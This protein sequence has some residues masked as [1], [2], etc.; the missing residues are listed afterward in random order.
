MD[1]AL[2]AGSAWHA[3]TVD[4]VLK[5]LDTDPADGLSG[6]EAARRLVERGPNTLG[7]DRGPSRLGLLAHQFGD[8]LIWVLLAAALI[9]GLLLQE[10]IDAGVILAIV[11]VNAVLGYIQEARAEDALARLR[12]LSAPEAVVVRSGTERRIASADLVPGDLIVLEVGDRV[13]AD[14]RIIAEV[15]FEA[16]ESTLTGESFAV[17]KQEDPVAA[18]SMLGDQRSMVFA[19]TAASA[20]RARAIVTDTGRAT[21]V[22]QI[23]GVLSKK[24]PPTP[25]QIELDKVGRRLA[26]LAVATAAAVFATGMVRG[27]PAEA[28]FLTAVALAVA[29]IP[30]GLAAVVTIT[31]SG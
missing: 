2:P 8:V 30:E 5:A 1:G 4:E 15:H 27:K 21:Q 6:D 24:E 11:I 25:L 3:M 10:W 13:P 18:G 12:E 17:T 19:G 22:G 7:R 16:E 31:L 14:C 26:V 9:S 20:G 29:A 28:M 23:A